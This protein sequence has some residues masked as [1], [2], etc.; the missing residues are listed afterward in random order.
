MSHEIER[1]QCYHANGSTDSTM[2]AMWTASDTTTTQHHD[3]HFFFIGI[4]ALRVCGRKYPHV[5][6]DHK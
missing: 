1:V 3:D 4:G 6:R 2:I 5:R